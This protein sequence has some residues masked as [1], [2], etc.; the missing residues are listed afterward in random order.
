VEQPS[1]D[2]AG[3]HDEEIKQGLLSKNSDSENEDNRY[4]PPEPT[5]NKLVSS[6]ILKGGSESGAAS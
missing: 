6:N 4:T 1:S 3:M 5:S 2:H